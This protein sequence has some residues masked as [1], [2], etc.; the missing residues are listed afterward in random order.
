MTFR[1]GRDSESWLLDG[2]EAAVLGKENK[3]KADGEFGDHAEG[4][5]GFVLKTIGTFPD[6]FSWVSFGF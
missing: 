1:E 3:S 2:P 5:G 6:D 4:V